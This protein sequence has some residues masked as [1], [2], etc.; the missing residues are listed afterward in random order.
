MKQYFYSKE[1]IYLYLTKFCNALAYSLIE[2]FGT[3]MLYQSGMPIWMIILIYGI[4]FGIM[5]LISPLFIKIS[6]RFG[7][8]AC[9]VI[10]SILNII[11]SYIIL[12]GNYGSI[13]LFVFLMAIPGALENP[14]ED[15]VSNRYIK[16]EHRGKYNSLRNISKI[17]GQVIASMI[18]A[19]GVVTDNNMAV[20]IIVIIFFMLYS[21]FLLLI[22]Y[23]PVTKHNI[24]FKETIKYVLTSRNYFTR[25]Y[26]LKTIH[27]LERLFIPLYIYIALA[28]FKL[29]SMAIIVSLLIQIFLILVVG[30]MT[31]R[32]IVK[33]NNLLSFLKVIV[34]SIFLFSESK[35]MIFINKTFQDNL[36]KLYDTN[37]ITSIQNIMKGYEEDKAFLAA[38]GQMSLCFTELLVFLF[39]ALIAVF[40]DVG[41]FKVIF[42]LSILSTIL[43]NYNI[44]KAYSKK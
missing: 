34:T 22:N 25:I 39:L 37:E 44:R 5:G 1:Y 18:V 13:V 21:L 27:V 30:R 16:T 26:A 7:V 24:S 15:A 17:L 14:I 2:I 12:S 43:I 20:F 33:T 11:N 35:T 41:V 4:R 36:E 42:I 23:K 6:K 19:W 40:I 32:N 10:A 28:D 9:A 29:F 31:D 3:V 8:G 38:A